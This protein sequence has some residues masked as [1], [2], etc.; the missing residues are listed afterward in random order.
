MRVVEAKNITTSVFIKL[1]Y[2]EDKNIGVP[3]F[4]HRVTYCSD[5]ETVSLHTMAYGDRTPEVHLFCYTDEIE[6]Y[7][8]EEVENECRIIDCTSRCV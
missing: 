6:V 4:V 7:G 2:V 3:R 8:Y 5:T 1:P